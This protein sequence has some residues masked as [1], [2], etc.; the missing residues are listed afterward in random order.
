M[1]FTTGNA[2]WNGGLKNGNGTISTESG[3]IDTTYSFKTRFEDDRT[4]TN[5][6]ELIG[7]ALAG[8][9]S[10]FLGSLLENAGHPADHIRTAAKVHLGR[11]EGG[12]FI[13]KIEVT[14][15]AQ[16]PGLND[17]DFQNHAETAKKGCPVSQ[18]LGGVPEITL[19]ARLTNG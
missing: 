9:Y 14:T 11:K 19:H 15:E 3:A 6:E 7:A 18:A 4:G 1:A 8:C 16:V 10:M 17:R 12:P 2:V 13:D 5:P